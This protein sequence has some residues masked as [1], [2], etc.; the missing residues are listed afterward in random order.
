MKIEWAQ[1]MSVG[2]ETIDNQHKRLLSQLN[3]MKEE[4]SSWGGV[5]VD[6]I[7]RTID[8][9]E[10]YAYEHLDYEEEYMKEHN[11]PGL[12]KHKKIHDSF[13]KYFEDFKQKFSTMYTSG[14]LFTGYIKALLTEAEEFLADWWI[15]HIL[16]ED[17]KYAVYIKTHEG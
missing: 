2:D 14:S 9:F 6:P 4:L 8:F 10:K 12:D 3:E 7:R 11:Y 15:N 5:D 13:R 16:K 1:E 17:H